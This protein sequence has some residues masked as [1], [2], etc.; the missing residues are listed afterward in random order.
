MIEIKDRDIIEAFK[1]EE[2]NP[3]NKF[4]HGVLRK[5]EGIEVVYER[6][7]G[8]TCSGFL[9]KSMFTLSDL[10]EKQIQFLKGKGYD[11]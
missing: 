5:K 10:S 11:L 7:S 6:I 9:E 3:E 8:E 4:F 1:I 2:K